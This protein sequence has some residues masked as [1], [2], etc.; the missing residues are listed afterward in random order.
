MQ[1]C[2]TALKTCGGNGIR[3]RAI[4]R[5]KRRGHQMSTHVVFRKRRMIWLIHWS[6][7]LSRGNCTQM[8]ED[9]E[10]F[11]QNFKVYPSRFKHIECQLWTRCKDYGITYIPPKLTDS[12]EAMIARKAALNRAIKTAAQ[13]KRREQMS[14]SNQNAAN[15]REEAS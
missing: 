13:K 2:C 12:V 4:L 10:K 14:K 9:E 15:A 1:R 6:K 8:N 5:D 3:R 11:K 7:Y